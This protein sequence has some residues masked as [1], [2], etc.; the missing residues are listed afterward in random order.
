MGGETRNAGVELRVSEPCDRWR[1]RR[2]PLCPVSGGRNARSSHSDELAKFPPGLA[3]LRRLIPLRIDI[4]GNMP[5]FGPVGE[6]D[7][8]FSVPCRSQFAAGWKTCL[9]PSGWGVAWQTVSVRK[10]GGAV[11]ASQRIAQTPKTLVAGLAAAIYLLRKTSCEAGWMPGS[12]PGMTSNVC[13]R[14]N[15]QFQTAAVSRHSFAISRRVSPEVC[16][17]FPCPPVQRAQGMP[18]ARCAR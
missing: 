7:V 15:P 13:A 4:A 9:A 11:I 3:V 10:G 2:P 6:P 1:G 18:G 5:K 8:L 17:K 12:S 14:T 16:Y